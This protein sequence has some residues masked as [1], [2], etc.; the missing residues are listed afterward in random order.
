MSEPPSGEAISAH[1]PDVLDGR[2]DLDGRRP[3]GESELATMRAEVTELQRTAR[4]IAQQVDWL[5]THAVLT[6]DAPVCDLDGDVDEAMAELAAQ[7]ERGERLQDELLAPAARKELQVSVDRHWEWTQQ[8]ERRQ[9]DVTRLSAAILGDD[10]P[11]AVRA[12]DDFPGAW[13][14]LSELEQDRARLESA[15]GA[16][17]RRLDADEA[18]RDEHAADIEAA[19]RAWQELCGRLRS[20]IDSAVARRA[21]LPVWFRNS[22]GLAPPPEAPTRWF[23]LATEILAYRVT[24]RIDT[25]DSPLGE[26]PT[27][28]ASARRRQ[29]YQRLRAGLARLT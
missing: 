29:W 14:A 25:A 17:R 5:L 16:A 23:E 15:A 18:V 22:L 9:A 10:E 26:A 2:P 13:Q 21:L 3:G 1:P 8:L 12:A 7:V 19:G 28:E 24:Y 20:L 6:P 11:A 4:R 27:D